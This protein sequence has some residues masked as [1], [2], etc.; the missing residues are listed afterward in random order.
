[1]TTNSDRANEVVSPEQGRPEWNVFRVRENVRTAHGPDGATAL[2]ILHGQMFRL[3]PVGS[4]ILEFLKQGS[5]EAE[6]AKQLAHEF[7][8]EPATAEADVHEF[9]EVLEKRHGLIER[10]GNSPA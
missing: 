1:M 7:G 10:A 4:R 3:N 2:D 5:T 8:V 9:I 6:I